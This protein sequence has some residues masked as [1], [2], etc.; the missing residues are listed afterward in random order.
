M[1]IRTKLL[2]A[3]SISII[4]TILSCVIIFIQ[5]NN[6][7]SKYRNTLDVGLPQTYNTT[8]LSRLSL[9]QVTFVQVYIMGMETKTEINTRREEMTQNIEELKRTL[10]PNNPVSQALIA[11]IEEKAAAMNASLDEVMATRDARGP[12]A[13]ANYYVDKTMPTITALLDESMALSDEIEKRFAMAE[14]DANSLLKRAFIIGIIATL[15]AVIIGIGASVVL[16]RR[17]AK[18]MHDL[19]KHVQEITKGNLAIEPINIQSKDEIGVLATSINEMR[20]TLIELLY[21]LSE[22]AGHLSATSEQLLASA[23]GVTDSA[24]VMLDG[25]KSGEESATAMSVSASESA[26]AMDETAIAVQ[27]IAES[28]QE[29]HTFAGN[30]ESLANKGSQNI[31]QAS[32]Q[33]NSI[34][35]STKLTTELIQKL[36]Q[37]SREIESITQVI[38]GIADQTNL[39]ALNA[40]IEAAR[41][42]EHGK[43]FAVVADE[44]RKLAEESNRSANQI[45]ALTNEIQQDTSNVELAMEESL[46]NVEQGVE[47]IDHAGQSF[48]QIVGAIGDMKGQIEDVS[49]V[50]E[51]ISATAEEVAASVLEISRSSDLTRE[52]AEKSF[53]S[54]EQQLSTLE[55][56]A[57]VANDLS[58]R[59]QEFQSI[60]SKYR[61]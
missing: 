19:E 59:A 17:I 48:D 20:T 23:E 43:G 22:S 40:S 13:A 21:N 47:I 12:E 1:S 16:T 38:T 52:N 10:N 28:T 31:H 35:Q 33:M 34:H 30:T 57:S 29:L 7:D 56:I 58:N 36:S 25:A 54:S 26:T 5:L 53:G 11:S 24:K 44:V 18:P 55:E 9:E 45:V 4:V 41:A 3:F 50:T 8:D 37:Q 42:G 51:Q 27:K 46:A 6:V 2:T 60:V 61:L 15:I 32:S 14:A 39:L 49:A